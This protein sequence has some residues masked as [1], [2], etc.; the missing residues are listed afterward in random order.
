MSISALT[1]LLHT[2]QKLFEK[3]F[4]QNGTALFWNIAFI[5]HAQNFWTKLFSMCNS[6]LSAG[7]DF[8][9]CGWKSAYF[10]KEK[11]KRKKNGQKKDKLLCKFTLRET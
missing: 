7:M 11:Q 8:K 10:F 6:R 1:K 9:K 3:I 4:L 2:G 5:V